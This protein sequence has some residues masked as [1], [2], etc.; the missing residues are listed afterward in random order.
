M[1]QPA[2]IRPLLWSS[3]A[4]EITLG[5][6]G[7]V[8]EPV[9]LNN[10]T[11]RVAACWKTPEWMSLARCE[12]SFTLR[13]LRAEAIWLSFSLLSTCREL[14]RSQDDE[15]KSYYIPILFYIRDHKILRCLLVIRS[16]RKYNSIAVFNFSFLE[17]LSCQTHVLLLA[18]TV[19]LNALAVRGFVV[20]VVSNVAGLMGT[21]LLYSRKCHNRVTVHGNWV[22]CPNM[23][24]IQ[25][26]EFWKP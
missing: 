3:K 14:Y 16:M 26:L 11:E 18:P 21:M 6:E 10:T 2:G 17:S 12:P 24:R 25:E 23:P 19:S 5:C 15:E 8:I 4:G 20:S 9:S 22:F 7:G 1:E 13:F